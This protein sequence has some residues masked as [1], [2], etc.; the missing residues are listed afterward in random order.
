MI[1]L[2]DTD[3]QFVC[4]IAGDKTGESVSCVQCLDHDRIGKHYSGVFLLDGDDLV[5]T[6]DQVR[7][8]AK[9]VAAETNMAF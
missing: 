3:Q 5:K 1:D 7:H 8:P 9:D 2:P 6:D 4:R